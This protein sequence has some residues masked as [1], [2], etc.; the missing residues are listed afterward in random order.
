VSLHAS[1]RW[2]VAFTEKHVGGPSPL[3]DPNRDRAFEI[4]AW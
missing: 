1:G 3:I 2:R 4:P